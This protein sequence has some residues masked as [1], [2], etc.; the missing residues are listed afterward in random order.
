MSSGFSERQS[1]KL[2]WTVTEEDSKF[3]ALGRVRVRIRVRIRLSMCVW[4]LHLH[5]EKHILM[6]TSHTHV[7]IYTGKIFL[8]M[9]ALL[10]EAVSEGR[11][12]YCSVL[13]D[14]LR[15]GWSY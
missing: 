10:K 5:P 12:S 15:G 11:Y 2:R 14:F 6:M 7:Y 1:Q 13:G 4:Y 9:H 3:R 8:K